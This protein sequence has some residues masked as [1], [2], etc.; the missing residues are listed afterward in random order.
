MRKKKVYK[1][2]IVKYTSKEKLKLKKGKRNRGE[3]KGPF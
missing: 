3:K 1:N 2:T